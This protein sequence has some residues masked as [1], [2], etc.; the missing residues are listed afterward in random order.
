MHKDEIHVRLIVSRRQLKGA[1][2][3][4]LL[5]GLA[6]ALESDTITL[7]TIYPAPSGVY[8]RIITTG[9][10]VLARDGGNTILVP[11]SNA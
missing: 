9:N 8:K 11:P 10:T 5:V 4:I 7:S 6:Y 1:L 2:A 3:L